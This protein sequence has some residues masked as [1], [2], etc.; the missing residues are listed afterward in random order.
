MAKQNKYLGNITFQGSAQGGSFGEK[1]IQLPDISADLARNRQELWNDYE[2]TKKAGLS[3][4]KLEQMRDEVV[5][6][7]NTRISQIL[8]KQ[9]ERF[10]ETASS[11]F[12]AWGKKKVDDII[13]K[14]T[15]K[16]DELYYQ[17]GDY[18][19]PDQIKERE[20]YDFADE[21][22]KNLQSRVAKW[23]GSDAARTMPVSVL[24]KVKELGST[25][26]A[27]LMRRHLK[28]QA[29][30][31]PG[32]LLEARSTWQGYLPKEVEDELIANNP[33]FAQYAGKQWNL[34][35]DDEIISGHSYTPAL[36]AAL[37]S[38][39]RESIF[40]QFQGIPRLAKAKYL[41]PEL[42]KVEEQIAS[43][44][45]AKERQL[46]TADY[47]MDAKADLDAAIKG[48][49]P[50]D[51]L[52][53]EED[54]GNV[55]GSRR[56][57]K[58]YLLKEF[59]EGLAAGV[60]SLEQIAN[61]ENAEFT[62]RG[63]GKSMTLGE[64]LEDEMASMDWEAL[65]VTA[66]NK[67]YELKDDQTEVLDKQL[68]DKM[69]K[70]LPSNTT[71]GTLNQIGKL[72]HDKTGKWP[73]AINTWMN[74]Q[75]KDGMPIK[76][77]L[78]YKR[79]KN[80]GKLTEDDLKG[81]P[82]DIAKVYRDAKQVDSE[83]QFIAGGKN[84]TNVESLAKSLAREEMNMTGDEQL[85]DNPDAVMFKNRAFDDAK[86]LWVTAKDDMGLDDGKA[87][88]YVNKMLQL[89]R[90]KY[91]EGVSLKDIENVVAR[92]KTLLKEVQTNDYNADILLTG[93]EKEI[94]ALGKW[95]GSGSLPSIY[96]YLGNRSGM[97]GWDFANKQYKA[98]TGK[99]LPE[100]NIVKDVRESDY[101]DKEL[102]FKF[103]SLSK[104]NRF[105]KTN[106][107]NG[108]L[109]ETLISR[110]EFRNRSTGSWY[111]NHRKSPKGVDLEGQLFQTIFGV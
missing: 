55:L 70:T 80:G 61:F 10:M 84:L 6:R 32:R 105:F 63:T 90:N 72:F 83:G 106:V 102:I 71:Q 27:Q 30:D 78:E 68:E 99:D 18:L 54:L 67:H 20:E 81:I 58:T 40:T 23:I 74:A 33:D 3:D 26:R 107:P 39:I 75:L 91:H 79:L 52:R 73:K 56:Q 1:Q 85:S 97:S 22:S 28:Q 111:F 108:E 59:G 53:I 60:Y 16:G 109:P 65:K 38:Q 92:N 24:R 62:H 8:D 46:I 89:N 35:S 77:W 50:Q 66:A 96:T 88:E 51:Y 104:F 45:S 86:A 100:P 41:Y 101:T 37:D 87:L 5:Y 93:T 11:A 42:R 76:D 21:A 34:D 44:H 15:A 36:R 14:E 48:G 31:I 64:Y 2:R 103:P 82:Y 57:A 110:A 43:E 7:H 13:L 25:A 12:A 47:V 49:T 4:L 98:A 29:S 95:N 9:E 19:D 94:E 17:L 69:M